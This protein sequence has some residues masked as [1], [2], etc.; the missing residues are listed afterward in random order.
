MR[1]ASVFRAMPSILV[2]LGKAGDRDA[3]VRFPEL[4]KGRREL[5]TAGASDA[6]RAEVVADSPHPGCTC[7]PSCT[8]PPRRP[9]G[10]SSCRTRRRHSGRSCCTTAGCHSCDLRYRPRRAR[11][12][13]HNSLLLRSI[14]ARICIAGRRSNP[15]PRGMLPLR[16]LRARSSCRTDHTR[17]A[18]P[19]ASPNRLRRRNRRSRGSSHPSRQSQRSQTPRNPA[20]LPPK[21]A[22][23]ARRSAA[24]GR[25]CHGPRCIRGSAPCSSNRDSPRSACRVRSK[26]LPPDPRRPG[27]PGGNRTRR[28]SADRRR[29]RLPAHPSPCQSGHR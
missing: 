17:R 12:F 4:P 22:R 15:H 5:P 7:C 14:R 3:Q 29:R 27:L 28:P 20:S 18:G 9:R 26:D 21:E 10:R 11:P 2:Q 25:R 23:A 1:A 19:P 6:Q 24:P 16:R 8:L 13:A